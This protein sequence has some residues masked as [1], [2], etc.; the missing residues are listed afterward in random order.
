[1]EFAYGSDVLRLTLPGRAA[2]QAATSAS[3]TVAYP[4][5]GED[6]DL[7]VQPNRDGVRTLRGGRPSTVNSRAPWTTE[8]RGHRG[9]VDGG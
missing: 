3:G 9:T 1:M 2:A 7:A 6:V 4:G 5:A 8:R